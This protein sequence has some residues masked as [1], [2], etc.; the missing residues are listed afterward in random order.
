MRN[1]YFS[2]LEASWR[3]VKVG[4]FSSLEPIHAHQ[5]SQYMYLSIIEQI[6]KFGSTK[7]VAQASRNA[8]GATKSYVKTKITLD[9]QV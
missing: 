7:I 9:F 8:F 5:G 1:V 3:P 2:S 6:S 4:P